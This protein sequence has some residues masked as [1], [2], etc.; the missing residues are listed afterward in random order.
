MQ[1][2]G[3]LDRKSR[4]ERSI[5]TVS[6]RYA[7]QRCCCRMKKVELRYY[8]RLM[9]FGVRTN[10]HAHR[11]M[12][13]KND[14]ELDEACRFR[15]FVCLAGLS[16]A[17]PPT[18]SGQIRRQND[19]MEYRFFSQQ[20]AA[21]RGTCH[22]CIFCLDGKRPALAA[23]VPHKEREGRRHLCPV[24]GRHADGGLDLRPYHR[25]AVFVL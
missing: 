19:G 23:D 20:R 25:R 8:A 6:L 9:C 7:I 5:Q 11:V 4:K 13:R 24:S 17:A 12:N 22:G 14:P 16:P 21:G 2:S 18:N 1:R 10:A 15:V 3:L